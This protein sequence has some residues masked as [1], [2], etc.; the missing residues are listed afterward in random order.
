MRF[1]PC[2]NC[3]MKTQ[4]FAIG[5]TVINL[6]LLTSTFFRAN[7]ATTPEVT[8][9]PRCRELYIMDDKGRVRAELKVFPALPK[10]KMPDGTMGYPESVMLRLISSTGGPHVKLATS[11]DGSGL[12]LSGET[13]KDY[14]QA[15]SRGTNQPFVKLVTKDGR[16]KVMQP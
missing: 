7:S 6:L 10:V 13:G 4:R 12:V 2:Q 5:L 8:Q 1:K 3:R 15:L 11:E 9:V 14:F 16:E